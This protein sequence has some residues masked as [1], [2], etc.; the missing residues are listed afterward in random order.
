MIMEHPVEEPT[1]DA[2]VPSH[3]R[4]VR[5]SIGRLLLVIAG[6]FF[7]QVILYGPSLLGWKILL[8]VD[9]LAAPGSYLP[10]TPDVEKVV[11][12]DPVLSDLI[13]G[14]EPARQFALA[15]LR[16]GRLPI[17]SPYE[18]CGAPSY[19]LP[20]C[21]AWFLNY[22]IAS[23]VV[24]AWSQVILSIFAGVGAHAFFRRALHVGFWPA[25][26]A[27]WCFPI[28]GTFIIWQGCGSPPVAACLPWL[29]LCVDQGIRKPR[30]WGGPLLAPLTCVTII[31]AAPD[32]AGQVLLVCGLFAVWC[33][34]DHHKEKWWR[35]RSASSFLAVGAG[36]ALGILMTL[37]MMLPLL[38]YS[39]TGA[40]MV[41]RS[42]GSEERP[43]VGVAELV[44]VI[45]P[46]VY[47]TTQQG[48]LR[49]VAGHHP[50]SSAGAYAGLL[51]TLVAAPLAWRSRRHRSMNWFWL[52]IGFLGLSWGLNVPGVVDLMRLPGMNMMS[53]NRLVFATSFAILALAAVGMDVLW[54]GLRP[55]GRWSFLPV[56]VLAV[57][58]VWCCYRTAVLPEPVRS[59][60]A[61][62]LKSG[63]AFRNIKDQA[64]LDAV[65]N[66]FFRTYYVATVLSALGIAAWLL[67]IFRNRL[68]RWAGPAL[69]VLMVGELLRFGYGFNSQ[70][71]P[72]MYYPR[73]P[74]L[75]EIAKAEPGRV[76]GHGCLYPSLNRPAGLH[77]VRGYDG[78]DPARM[79][80]LVLRAKA[81]NSPVLRAA[82]TQYMLP[83]VQPLG[84]G[85]V[86]L[87]PIL[88]M[89]N[90]RHVIFRG[91]P[92]ENIQPSFSG[93]DYWALTNPAALP[94]VFVPKRVETEPDGEKRL[95]KMSGETFSP[96]D[97]AYVEEPV[98]LP[99]SCAGTA[100]IVKEIPRQISV[101][102]DMGTPGL[103]V[104]TDLWDKGWHAYLNDREVPILVTNHAVR[105]VVAPAGV[106][107]IEFR[108]E[109]ASMDLGLW[110]AGIA[111]LLVFGWAALARHWRRQSL[112][113]DPV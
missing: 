27:A 37:P 34:L 31:S 26:I 3:R 1:F 93:T 18:Y 59:Q 42:Q 74:M 4:R 106:G 109:P 33:H 47:G 96:R 89:L 84:E 38:E 5:E 104:L 20:L 64:G 80:H 73:V 62:F 91:S 39:R 99:E 107:N 67:V 60:L 94:R 22:L 101:S 8:P 65:Q 77:E 32:V 40:R 63:Q 81:E 15:E 21:P 25:A 95:E 45:I 23:P 68:S 97:V 36:W 48:S 13:C 78:V 110:L 85:N 9:I 16:E 29:L 92:P 112:T 55:D 58:M 108:Y 35:P 49:L 82:M 51:A 98:S 90:V 52:G 14:A 50:E 46:E 105:G 72:W 76:I 111:M 41:A 66:T 53:F 44:P 87:H 75:D 12:H 17:W 113:A 11:T 71:E 103:V 56:G 28:S 61:E 86:R 57:L 30:S 7:T 2:T 70:C 102:V 69:G 24:L 19:R 83:K 100:T 54:R 79:V 43:P 88:D 10:R 6:I